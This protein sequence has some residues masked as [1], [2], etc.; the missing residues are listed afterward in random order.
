MRWWN[1]A[2]TD[3]KDKDRRRSRS[4]GSVPDPGHTHVTLATGKERVRH[5]GSGRKRD[6]IIE[7]SE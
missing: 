6:D 1:G 2:A 4:R 3:S 7:M 5:A